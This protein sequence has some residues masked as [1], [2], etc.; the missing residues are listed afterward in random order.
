MD[1]I[2]LKNLFYIRALGFPFSRAVSSQFDTHFHENDI[3]LN[4]L[5]NFAQCTSIEFRTNH[6]GGNQGGS[7]TNVCS[8]VLIPLLVARTSTNG[9]KWA[10]DPRLMSLTWRRSPPPPHLLPYSL[11]AS[12]ASEPS[13]SYQRTVD[14]ELSFI[15]TDA[16]RQLTPHNFTPP[17]E[18]CWCTL[19]TTPC[20]CARACVSQRLLQRL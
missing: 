10:G 5:V 3:I 14:A 11:C 12:A 15:S 2:F 16:V 20:V 7:R 6:F 1:L 13:A 4:T 8:R 18:P 17:P 9:I 19:L